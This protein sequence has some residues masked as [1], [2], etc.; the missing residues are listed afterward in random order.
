ML[1]REYGFAGWQDLAGEVQ[2]RLGDG[3][4]WAAAQARRAIH[5]DDVEQLKQLLAEYPALL[6]SRAD[7]KA[8][9]VLGMATSSYAYDVGE[10][11]RRATLRARRAQSCS[12]MRAR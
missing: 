6:S 10:T 1:A 5:D 11:Q 12:S 7:D 9:G 3:L 8:G 2:R 4:E